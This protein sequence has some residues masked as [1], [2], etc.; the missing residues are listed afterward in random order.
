MLKESSEEERSHPPS[1]GLADPTTLSQTLRNIY[2]QSD[3]MLHKLALHS[4]ALPLYP[5]S[6]SLPLYPHSV[7]LPLYPQS[8]S[9]PLYPHSDS[10]PLYP[11]SVSLPL[12]PH[13]V[14]LPLYP[15]LL[16]TS[17]CV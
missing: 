8:V 9:L 11:Q 14:S 5:H 10:L 12:Y 16:Y 2:P 13:S 3:S 7:S 15:C 17:R 6:V 1:L 4:G